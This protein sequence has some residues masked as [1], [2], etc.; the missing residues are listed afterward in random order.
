M[1]YYEG[2][3]LF[4]ARVPTSRI[5]T[6]YSRMGEVVAPFA[7][8]CLVGALFRLLRGRRRAD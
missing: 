2:E 8:I 7:L 3:H 1:S 6:P 4:M 5:D